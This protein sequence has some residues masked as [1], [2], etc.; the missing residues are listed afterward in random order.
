[1]SRADAVLVLK[2]EGLIETA[3][4]CRFLAAEGGDNIFSLIDGRLVAVDNVLGR[5]VRIDGA[6]V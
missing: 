2:K 3:K 4:D 1:M 5:V 6:P